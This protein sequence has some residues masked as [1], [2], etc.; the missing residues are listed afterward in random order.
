[1]RSLTVAVLAAVLGSSSA[2]ADPIDRSRSL[3]PH[4]IGPDAM[5]ASRGP[6]AAT[7]P[8]AQFPRCRSS[9]HQCCSGRATPSL[10]MRRRSSTATRIRRAR[11][12]T[13]M[14]ASPRCR[15]SPQKSL[16]AS[17]S[18]TRPRMPVGRKAHTPSSAPGSSGSFGVN[19]VTGAWNLF[20]EGWRDHGRSH[21]STRARL[22]DDGRGRPALSPPRL[23]GPMAA[24]ATA[25]SPLKQTR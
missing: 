11:R 19:T 4:S 22:A 8:S 5:A 7:R 15:C 3:V 10:S 18:T 6:R 20:G 23:P 24:A 14:R 16:L 17:R 1:M 2:S 9:C 25:R 12:F 13:S 21:A